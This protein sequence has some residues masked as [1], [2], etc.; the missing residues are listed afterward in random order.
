[1]S[2]VI[3]SCGHIKNLSRLVESISRQNIS[4][5]EIETLLILNNHNAAETPELRKE[6][7]RLL[8]DLQIYELAEKGVN[9]A[10][11]LGLEKAQ[12][13]VIYF[14]DDD[15]SFESRDIINEHLRLHSEQPEVLAFGGGYRLPPSAGL[16]DRIYNL[17]QMRWFYS[18]FTGKKHNTC[19]ETFQ[20]L[21]GNFS[22]KKHLTELN[23][24][25][26]EE[27]IAYGSSEYDYCIQ[28]HNKNLTL[29]ATEM[30]LVHYTQENF[31]SVA[32]KVFL[33]G[34]GKK[35]LDKKYQNLISSASPNDDI[36]L[37][38]KDKILTTLYNYCYW[39]GYF[40][41]ESKMTKIVK[42]V[43]KDSFNYLNL[44]RYRILQKFQK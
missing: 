2:L 5:G 43:F 39:Y 11:N 38:L 41:D 34:I 1:M 16:F 23:R 20:I 42:L 22:V 6:L 26:F 37:N 10:R 35:I 30:E 14:V 32:R 8:P 28:A 18:G 19:Y 24:M 40:Y 9:R 13:E 27:S 33:Q 17:I 4:E 44:L 36:N 12:G 21:G 3:P 7:L 15:C 25:K 31:G 29:M